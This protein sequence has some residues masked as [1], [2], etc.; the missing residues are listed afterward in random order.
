LG[1]KILLSPETSEC[2]CNAA[3]IRRL[4]G[5]ERVVKLF[6]ASGKRTAQC[7]EIGYGAQFVCAVRFAGLRRPPMTILSGF[8]EGVEDDWK[9]R[10]AII[11]FLIPRTQ[12]VKSKR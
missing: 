9:K 5:I 3:D 10:C 4:G 12:K 2:A 8:E 7:I 6:T 11:E 1:I